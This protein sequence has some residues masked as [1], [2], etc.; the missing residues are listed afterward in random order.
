[1]VLIS[2]PKSSRQKLN[3]PVKVGQENQDWQDDPD[4]NIHFG[5]ESMDAEEAFDEMEMLYANPY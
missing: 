4:S 2:D 1:M 5:E 3:T